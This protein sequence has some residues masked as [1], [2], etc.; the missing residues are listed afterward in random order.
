MLESLRTLFKLIYT[1]GVIYRTTGVTFIELSS[2]TPKQLSVFDMP[3]K[4]HMKNEK[5]SNALTKIKERYGDSCIS[6][7]LVKRK[8]KMELGV[9][10]EVN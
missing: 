6:Q 4:S 10:F 3:D 1:P 8:K 7:G 2:F 5:I 9:L